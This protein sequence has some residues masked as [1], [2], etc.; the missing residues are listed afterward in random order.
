MRLILAFAIGFIG[1]S[2]LGVGDGRAQSSSVLDKLRGANP[3]DLLTGPT[4]G[5]RKS[6]D[7][8]NLSAAPSTA[9]ADAADLVGR[10]RE[11]SPAE[12][13]ELLQ[14]QTRQTPPDWGDNRD[15]N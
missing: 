4:Q 14:D 8:R 2:T 3:H 11:I 6:D 7:L 13:Q 15:R 1:L 5:P 9:P 10:G 12:R